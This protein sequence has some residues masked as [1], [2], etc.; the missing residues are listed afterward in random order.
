[1]AYQHPL[2]YLLGIEGLAL[3]Q[4]F[5]GDHDRDFGEDRVAEMRRLLADP[6]LAGEGVTAAEV[7]T[8]TGYRAWSSTYDRPGNGL[9]ALEEPFVQGI[10]DTLPVGDVLDAA[11]G[12]GR[13]T[14]ALAARGHRVIGVDSSPQML[15][16]A[17]ERVPQARFH[18]GDLHHLP[19][20]DDA[21][22]LVVCALA[23]AHLP[24]L[25]PAFAEF[26]RVLRPGGHLVVT[27]VHHERVALGSLAHVRSAQGEP[28]LIPSH[29]YRAG[30]YLGAALPAGFRVEAC[31]EPCPP[32]GNGPGAAV[33][34]TWDTWPWSLQ[35]MVPSA[36]AAVLDSS[37]AVMLW[38]FRKG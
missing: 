8:V 13:H 9:F 24:E 12:T 16:R 22:D 37:P 3:L 20:P 35:A 14:A 10:V 11:C 15:A 17:T 34:G 1:M 29:R 36:T 27:D 6:A 30:D 5:A 25:G 7:D 4:T 31:E 38:H 19:L 28:A 26:A 2:H 32:T 33:A 23:L 21:V 18:Q